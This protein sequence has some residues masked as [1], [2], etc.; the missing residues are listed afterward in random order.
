[1]DHGPQLLPVPLQWRALKSGIK[2]P[3]NRR[4]KKR[5]DLASGLSWENR[6]KWCWELDIQHQREGESTAWKR[7]QGNCETMGHV[8]GQRPRHQLSTWDRRGNAGCRVQSLTA[9]SKHIIGVYLIRLKAVGFWFESVVVVLLGTALQHF[10]S[11]AALLRSGQGRDAALTP[12][13]V[14]THRN[15]ACTEYSSNRVCEWRQDTSQQQVFCQDKGPRKHLSASHV[16]WAFRVQLVTDALLPT[17]GSRAYHSKELYKTQK[18]DEC[19][20]SAYRSAE[21]L[22][23]EASFAVQAGVGH[24]SSVSAKWGLLCSEILG[25]RSSV[26]TKFFAVPFHHLISTAASALYR[27]VI[28]FISQIH[29]WAVTGPDVKLYSKKKK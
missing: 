1:M 6:G 27:N 23:C 5:S 20:W 17:L 19:L 10:F 14:L 13:C 22:C 25:W 12:H 9:G 28:C 24:P 15:N 2:I 29:W 16:G 4:K 21:I 18:R 11:E 8:W 3:F 7:P 26:N